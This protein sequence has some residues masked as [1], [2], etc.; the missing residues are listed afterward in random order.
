MNLPHPSGL[1]RP[2]TELSTASNA[3]PISFIEASPQQWEPK[4]WGVSG[5]NQDGLIL[6]DLPARELRTFKSL[7]RDAV[8]H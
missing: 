3:W 4:S 7:P 5:R 2:L 8:Q 1:T 6:A